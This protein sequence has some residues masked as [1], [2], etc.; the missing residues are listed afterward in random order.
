[1]HIIPSWGHI[2]LILNLIVPTLYCTFI[3]FYNIQLHLSP[4]VQGQ[5]NRF[6]KLPVLHRIILLICSI[7]AGVTSFFTFEKCKLLFAIQFNEKSNSIRGANARFAIVILT[8]ISYVSSFITLD[9]LLNAAG[10]KHGRVIVKKKVVKAKK[11]KYLLNRIKRMIKMYKDA[12]DVRGGKYFLL[13]VRFWE[14]IEFLSQAFALY[15]FA[16]TKELTY[17]LIIVTLMGSNSVITMCIFLF[18][19][20]R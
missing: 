14:I 20:I 2:L 8:F 7:V 9:V 3:Y 17:I 13:E 1:M 4:Q 19:E 15:E 10:F 18:N 6:F 5:K 16:A 12:T 11:S